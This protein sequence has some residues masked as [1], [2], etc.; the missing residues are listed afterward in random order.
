MVSAFGPVCGLRTVGSIGRGTDKDAVVIA[1]WV[2]TWTA[3][4]VGKW[5]E[6][7]VV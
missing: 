5:R 3:F 1:M 6:R 7:D 2:R 4:T